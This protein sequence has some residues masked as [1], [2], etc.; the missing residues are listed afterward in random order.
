MKGKPVIVVAN[1]T[2]PMIFNEFEDKVD[3]ILVRFDIPEK[4]TLDIISGRYEPSGLLPVQMPANMETVEKQLEDVP[5]D[6][7]CHKDSEGNIYNFGFGMNWNGVI[8]DGR[9]EKYGLKNNQ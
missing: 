2:R 9:T 3:G 6:M 8:N 4:A 7:E 1:L 5:F